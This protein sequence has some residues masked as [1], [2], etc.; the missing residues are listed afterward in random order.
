[1]LGVCC[2]GKGWFLEAALSY[3]AWLEP[4]FWCTYWLGSGRYSKPRTNTA[5]RQDEDALGP[6][7][8][9]DKQETT[10]LSRMI[11]LLKQPLAP[12]FQSYLHEHRRSLAFASITWY[13]ENSAPIPSCHSEMRLLITRMNA[14][15]SSLLAPTSLCFIFICGLFFFW[16]MTS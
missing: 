12:I 1:M 4:R 10:R 6:L 5:G 8:F 16:N 14:R 9:L 15:S 13:H 2:A 11:V 3:C 7:L